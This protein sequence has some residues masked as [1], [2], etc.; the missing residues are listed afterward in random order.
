MDMKMDSL[1]YIHIPTLDELRIPLT[2][3]PDATWQYNTLKSLEW[4]GLANIKANR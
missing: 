1:N 3:K 2:S 4:V